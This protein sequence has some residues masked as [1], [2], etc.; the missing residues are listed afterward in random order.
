[1][2]WVVYKYLNGMLMKDMLDTKVYLRMGMD[3][4]QEAKIQERKFGW[5]V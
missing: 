1:M 4:G 2:G 5:V 3:S